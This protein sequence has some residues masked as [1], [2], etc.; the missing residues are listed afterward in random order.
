MAL[1]KRINYY[2]DDSGYYRRIP[3]DSWL[4]DGDFVGLSPVGIQLE[5]EINFSSVGVV[6]AFLDFLDIESN[7]NLHES[8]VIG[9]NIQTDERTFLETYENVIGMYESE[10]SQ[11]YE[12]DYDKSEYYE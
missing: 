10:C 4:Q 12:F 3:W 1:I 8:D 7:P 9:L 5:S 6:E 2:I 11:T